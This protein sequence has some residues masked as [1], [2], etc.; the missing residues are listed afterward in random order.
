MTRT[1]TP[2][3]RHPPRERGMAML[4]VMIA[5]VMASIMARGFLAAQSTNIG[6]SENIDGQARARAIAESGLALTLQH[7]QANADWRETYAEGDWVTA[8]AFEGGTFTV[9]VF[10]GVYDTDSQAVSGDGDLADDVSDTIAVAVTATYNGVTHTVRS[11]VT[12]GVTQSRKLLLITPNGD[13]LTEQD[14]M[15][16]AQFEGWGYEV[17]ALSDSASHTQ[18]TAA[19]EEADVV[20]VSEEANSGDVGSAL[21]LATIGVVAE[22]GYLFDELGLTPSNTSDTSDDTIEIINDGHYITRDFPTGGLVIADGSV[23]ILTAGLVYSSGATVLANRDGLLGDISPT[24]SVF[25][26]GD[27]RLDGGVSMGRRV[28]LPVGGGS[29]DFA[30]LNA[31]GLTLIKRSLAWAA[32]EPENP[33]SN[34][35]TA[36]W[37]EE[38]RTIRQVWQYGKSRGLDLHSPITSDV[39]ILPRTGNRLITSGNVRRGSLPPHSKLVEVTYPEGEEVFEAHIFFKDA[40]GTKAQAWAQFDLVFRGERYPLAPE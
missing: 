8:Q 13:N 14:A 4:L 6:I 10:D 16:A 33:V 38:N 30:R 1:L 20:Y 18:Y 34:G 21:T 37:F 24:L 40:L 7:I 5:V 22:E 19:L 3:R 25:D 17:T 39:D 36:R 32:T 23:P 31:D 2:S 27:A 12:P 9:T 29:F 15:K 35:L 26:A 28:F 11:N